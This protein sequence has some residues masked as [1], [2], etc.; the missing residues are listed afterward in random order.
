MTTSDT[1]PYNVTW[2]NGRNYFTYKNKIVATTAGDYSDCIV[3]H[4]AEYEEMMELIKKNVE[5]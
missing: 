2:K 3:Y 4:R 5:I 1:K